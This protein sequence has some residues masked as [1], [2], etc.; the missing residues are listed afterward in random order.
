[1][2]TPILKLETVCSHA[3]FRGKIPKIT[4]TDRE[5]WDREIDGGFSGRAVIY[6]VV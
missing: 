3:S 4:V 1:M 6:G 5:R 2:R